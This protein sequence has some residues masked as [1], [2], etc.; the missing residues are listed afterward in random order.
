MRIGFANDDFTR[1][2][3]RFVAEERLVLTVT[4]PAA[5]LQVTNLPAPTTATTKSG[6]AGKR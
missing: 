3:V 5:V 4:R 2:L 1:T 6:T